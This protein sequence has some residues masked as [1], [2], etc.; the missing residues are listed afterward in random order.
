MAGRREDG[1]VSTYQ[2]GAVEIADSVWAYLQPDGSWGWSN[3]GLVSAPD[4]SILVDTLFDLHLTRR[5]LEEL[6][7][8][9]PSPIAT[10]VNTHANGDHCYGNEL[11]TGADIVASARCAAEMLDAPPARLADLMAAADAMGETGAYLKRIFGAFDF[12]G[13]TLT[14]PTRTFSGALTLRAGY[15]VVELIEV[16][17]AHTAGDVIVHVPDAG[18][19][20][21]GDIAFIGGHPIMWAGPVGNWTAALDT[22]LAMDVHTIVPGHGPVC[23]QA[24]IRALRGYFEALTAEA[25]VRFDAGLSPLEAARDIILPDYAGWTDGERV[26][27]NV[28]ALYREWGASIPSDIATVFG[29]MAAVAGG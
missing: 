28:T 9:S 10:L 3:A 22:I 5:M 18:V 19:V 26:V 4:S 24:E 15:R 7:R 27:A 21:T 1:A 2:R 17:P 16:G 6:R 13:I 12:S 23:G 25:R 8:V 14:P 11:V 20:F 29:Y